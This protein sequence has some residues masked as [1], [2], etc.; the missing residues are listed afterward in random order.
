MDIRTEI[1]R[2]YNSTAYQE[3]SRYYKRRSSFD[4]LG[5]ARKEYVH[6]NFLAWLLD[7]AETHGCGVYTLK[8][9]LQ[10]LVTSKLEF[11]TCNHDVF[12][13]ED[14]IDFFV[15]D[16]YEIRS[17][18]VKTEVVVSGIRDNSSR[19][20]DILLKIE[21][22]R[23]DEVRTLP[24][25]IENK[26]NSR[27]HTDQTQAYYDWAE[28]EFANDGYFRPLFVFLS[29]DKPLELKSGGGRRCACGSYIKTDYQYLV[30]FV[31]EPSFGRIET[32]DGRTLVSDYL[33]CLSYSDVSSECGGFKEAVMATS[34]KERELLRQFWKSNHALLSA[35]LGALSEDED[36]SDAE[37][38]TFRSAAAAAT[39][40]KDYSRYR[41]RGEEETYGKR[42][43]V[44]AVIRVFLDEHTDISYE[45][46]KA[47]FP[48]SLH[49][50]GFSRLSTEVSDPSRYFD[51]ITLKDGKVIVCSNQWGVGNIDAFIDRARDH[52]IEVEKC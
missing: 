44:Q 1:I 34:K 47:A 24:V 18:E 36:F 5:V 19:R 25:I 37:R 29:P 10:L 7:P 39:S 48:D 4:I 43:I 15:A 21:I 27:E 52:G 28:R 17:A 3:L 9:F 8:K 2:L 35:A 14:Y 32:E 6:S 40:Q 50:G 41:I 16:D 33:R 11:C 22:V 13:P 46:F 51:P 12:L 42:G 30:D 26:V 20:I 31:I 23:G 38:A 49:T 45:E